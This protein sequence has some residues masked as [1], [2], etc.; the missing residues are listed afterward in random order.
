MRMNQITCLRRF[1]FNWKAGKWNCADDNVTS[2]V[3]SDSCKNTNNISANIATDNKTNIDKLRVNVA[4]VNR[5]NND[6]VIAHVV[7]EDN[8]RD[9]WPKK[10]DYLLSLVGFCVDLS[11]VWRFPK[12][13]YRNGGGK[14]A[15][16]IISTFTHSNI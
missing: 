10:V 9:M 11:V 6:T 3:D 12:V 7:G 2:N 8:V 13:C 5:C 15:I 1:V 14:F 16:I 4:N